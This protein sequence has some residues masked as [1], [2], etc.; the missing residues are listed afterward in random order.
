[1]LG[2]NTSAGQGLDART[3]VL[4]DAAGAASDGQLAGQLEDDILGRRP[5][6][7]LAREL[8]AQHVRR[9]L[10]NARPTKQTC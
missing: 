8:H 1:M 9:A 4:D 3:E 6:A 5:A 2:E 7:Q 10:F